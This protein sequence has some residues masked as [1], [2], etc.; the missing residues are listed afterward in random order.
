MQKRIHVGSECGCCDCCAYRRTITAVITSDYAAM[1]NASLPLYLHGQYTLC[2]LT[3]AADSG[4]DCVWTGAY[5]FTFPCDFFGL[6]T[7]TNLTITVVVKL[8]LSPTEL[9]I[10]VNAQIYWCVGGSA[11]LLD[12]GSVVIDFAEACECPAAVVATITDLYIAP[13]DCN[14]VTG[15]Y[16]LTVTLTLE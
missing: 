13:S 11:V 12:G 4:T 5:T 16:S 7:I 2:P 9:A 6:G 14:G 1:E 15:P 3:R 8:T 10:T